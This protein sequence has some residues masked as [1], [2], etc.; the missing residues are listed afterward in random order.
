MEAAGKRQ[1]MPMVKVHPSIDE[2]TRKKRNGATKQTGP[3]A[4][5][6]SNNTDN[7]EYQTDHFDPEKPID[8]ATD[9]CSL[10]NEVLTLRFAW[11][12]P[13]FHI[14]FVIAGDRGTSSDFCSSTCCRSFRR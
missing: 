11:F 8:I 14:N 2:S 12:S 6:S 10:C 3:K 5:T 4:V 1:V 9:T 7:D 13:Q